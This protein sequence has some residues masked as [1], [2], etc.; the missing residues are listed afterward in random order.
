MSCFV[1][2]RTASVAHQL[3]D[4]PSV[5]FSYRTRKALDRCRGQVR[6]QPPPETAVYV[7]DLVHPPVRVRFTQERR[8]LR[9][10]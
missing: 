3:A 1:V 4:M 7:G 6:P 9:C 10:P 5:E 8:A 2:T